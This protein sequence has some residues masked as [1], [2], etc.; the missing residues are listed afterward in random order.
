V[1]LGLAVLCV[2]HVGCVDGL[3]KHCR[4]LTW[5]LGVCDSSIGGQARTDNALLF[6]L[7]NCL[8][9][10]CPAQRRAVLCCAVC[11]SG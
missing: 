6:Q 2:D 3:R 8:V 9:W 7:L 5:T 10:L 11:A 1:V 4:T